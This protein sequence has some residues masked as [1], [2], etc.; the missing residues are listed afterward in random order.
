MPTLPWEPWI[1]LWENTH[2]HK[3]NTRARQSSLLVP[4][5][6]KNLASAAN[7]IL[8]ISD[9][10]AKS[11]SKNWPRR[12]VASHPKYKVRQEKPIEEAR[13]KAM[14]VITTRWFYRELE[15]IIDQYE[16]EPED[17]WNMDEMG[18]R[19]GVGRGRWV[20]RSRWREKQREIFKHNWFTRR[21]RACYHCR[22]NIC[23]GYD[24]TSPDNCEG[25]GDP[26]KM[27][28]WYPRWRLPNWSLRVWV[29]KWCPILLMVA[30][31]G[32]NE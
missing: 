21:P 29:C 2:E 24:D 10:D 26:S 19:I 15:E 16:I 1:S 4:L 18:I 23:W 25:K 22:S 27:V 13:Q 12:W 31:L 8:T 17:F 30:A 28:C 3:V 6:Y 11:V 5:R 32:G 9:P 14:N 20:I 7:H